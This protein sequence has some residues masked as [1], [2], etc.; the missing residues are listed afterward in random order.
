MRR[1]TKYCLKK[2]ASSATI[3]SRKV[4]GL[5]MQ[6]LKKIWNDWNWLLPVIALLLSAFTWYYKTSTEMPAR[7]ID[8]EKHLAEHISKSEQRFVK[9]ESDQ[10]D[11]KLTLTKLEAMMTTANTDLT[12][13]KNFITTEAHRL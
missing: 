7:I 9:I 10:N 12:I 2:S 6:G 5:V 4:A 1:S 8:C 3:L 13:I 11:I